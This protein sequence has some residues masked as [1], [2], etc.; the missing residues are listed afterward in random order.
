LFDGDAISSH[1]PDLSHKNPK[2]TA[3]CYRISEMGIYGRLKRLLIGKPLPSSAFAEE[4]L[5]IPGGLAIL[6]SDALSSVAYATEEILL[7]LIV[8]GWA[9]MKVALPLAILIAVLLVIIALSY[10]QTVKAYPQGGGAY[11][12]SKDNLGFG[13]SMVAGAALMI[14]YILTVTVSISAGTAAITSAFPS[15][16]GHSI[17]MCVI[18]IGLLTWA[19]LRGLRASGALFMFPTYAF[20]F[21]V[22]AMILTG[23]IR[24]A[25]GDIPAAPSNAEMAATGGLGLFLL[26]RAFSSGCT[27]LTGIEAISDGVLV[28]KQPEWK[29]ARHTLLILA[30][31]LGVMFVGIT[32]LVV[33][34]HIEPSEGNTLISLLARQVFGEGMIYY[35]FQI[36]TLLILLLAANTSYADFPR[37]AYFLARDS[38]LPRQLLFLGDRLVYSN[39]IIL[40]SSCAIALIIVFQAQTNA[41]IPLYAIGV[42]LSFTLSQSGMVRRWLRLKEE[43]WQMGSLINGTGAFSTFCVL[44]IITVSK[45]IYGAWIV[46]LAI[47]CLIMLFLSI[48]KH[49][50][51]VRENIIL[52]QDTMSSLVEQIKSNSQTGGVNS[53]ALVL[54]GS[55]SKG[56]MQALLYATSISN[57]VVA[58]HVDI[59]L[60]KQDQFVQKWEALDLDIPLVILNSPYR[61]LIEP[62][63]DFASEYETQ[64]PDLYVTMVIPNMVTQNWW[65]DLLHNQNGFFIRSALCSKRSRVFT[66]VNYYV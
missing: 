36:I 39:G 33:N 37:L 4:R 46:V 64:H 61:S 47:P 34:Y 17:L 2:V 5:S 29:N 25:S 42:F 31:L 3:V 8:A 24:L 1:Q 35:F 52:D 54:V 15:L 19:N 48:R 50:E 21:G 40:L 12:V 55:L 49:Y 41:I 6:A 59:G 58:V 9:A 66:H 18:F 20:V 22:L 63:A 51:K 44:I 7:V 56:T 43:G 53:A 14:D 16:Q 13:A 65:E 10:R 45:F 26:L 60:N 27:A 38:F 30:G 57:K 28:F 32:Y 23:V 62:L 11:L